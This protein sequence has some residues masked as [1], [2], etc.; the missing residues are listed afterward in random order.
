MMKQVD[1]GR[2]P[3][4]TNSEDVEAREE[5]RI[6]LVIRWPVGGI[7]TFIRYVFSQWAGVRPKLTLVLPDLSES[8]ALEEDLLGFDVRW[9]YVDKNASPIAI[10]RAVSIALRE[11]EYDVVHAHGFTS[12]LC[13]AWSLALHR[14]IFSIATSHDVLLPAQVRGAKG[15][16]KRFV[17]ARALNRY[18]V[19]HSV[20]KDAQANLQTMVPGVNHKKCTVITNG[21]DTLRFLDAEPRNL[22]EDLE[23]ASDTVLL[24]F[25]G[26][27]M[28]QKG[29]RYLVD[30]IELLNVEQERAFKVACFGWGGFIR[31]EQQLLM[32]RGLGDYFI[33]MPF[34][35]NVAGSMKGVDVVVMPSLWEACGLLAMEALT[36]G[37]PLVA[38]SCIGLREVCE[39]TPAIMIKPQSGQAIRDGVIEAI[40]TPKEKFTQFTQAAALRYDVRKTVRRIQELYLS[41]KRRI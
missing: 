33:F 19:I 37:V 30:A 38:A 28:A 14:R 5:I 18:N 36:A 2:T 31:E 17:M 32:E 23:L 1:G 34:V 21:I 11:T 8:A 13:A 10:I 9:F 35:S 3:L 12:A 15:R 26:R 7:R 29:F 22:R 27:F 16:L 24:G 4:G 40:N 25:F 39:D 6:L 20:S 41:E